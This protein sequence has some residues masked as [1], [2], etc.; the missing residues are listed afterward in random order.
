[1]V[2][3]GSLDQG[4]AKEVLAEMLSTG[5]SLPSTI[6][7]LGIT[8]IDA[9][10]ITAL[11]TRLIAENESIVAQYRAGNGKAIGT[12]IGQAKKLNPNANPGLVKDEI[13][14]LLKSQ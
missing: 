14:R 12:L 6:T 8:K 10:E 4:R 2:L 3:R 11:A 13:L 9:S 5:D 1:M 7:R